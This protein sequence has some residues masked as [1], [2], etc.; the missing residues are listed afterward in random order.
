VI[1]F[2]WLSRGALAPFT[3]FRWPVDGSWVS[4]P[5]GAPEGAGVHACRIGQLAWWIGEE[6]WRVELDGPVRERETQIEAPRARLLDRVTAWD[7][8]AFAKACVART[9]AFAAE[10]PTAE[11]AD[12]LDLIKTLDAPTASFVASVAAVAARGTKQAFAEERAWQARWLARALDLR[13]E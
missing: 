13:E 6:L 4:A 12:Y 10:A 9:E 7:P 5:P 2:K 8:A 1:A 3:G 11:L